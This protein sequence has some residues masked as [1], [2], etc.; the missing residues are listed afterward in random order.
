VQDNLTYSMLLDLETPESAAQLLATFAAVYGS[1]AAA[2]QLQD[3][4]RALKPKDLI[5]FAKAH[6]SDKTRT[7]LV[8]TAP[9]KGGAK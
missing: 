9:E 4:A 2:E 8:L 6:L 3:A 7:S 1:P 5:A